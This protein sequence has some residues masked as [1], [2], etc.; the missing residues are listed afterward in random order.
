MTLH[1]QPPR[2]PAFAGEATLKSTGE[3]SGNK[4]IPPNTI[5]LRIVGGDGTG[6]I[7]KGS[8]KGVK[9]AI[10]KTKSTMVCDKEGT[11]QS[12][13]DWLTK[14]TS[15][16]SVARHSPCPF[17]QPPTSLTCTGD[18][19]FVAEDPLLAEFLEFVKSM[20]DIRVGWELRASKENV[21]K[22]RS[23][24]LYTAKQLV[25]PAA[26]SLVLK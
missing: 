16:K 15:V 10:S 18:F 13:M 12:L 21:A 26:G 14:N 17:D 1:F 8:D 2:G 25:M 5:L 22:P 7:C 19:S 3:L 4:K 9:Y 11:L 23:L 24:V 20:A 6:T